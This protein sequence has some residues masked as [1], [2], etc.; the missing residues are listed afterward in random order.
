MI[1]EPLPANLQIQNALTL[2]AWVYPTAY[3]TINSG[4]YYAQIMGS[5]EDGVYGG[6]GLFISGANNNGD[7]VPTGGI[8]F[9][10]GDGSTFHG[11]YTASQVPLNQWTLVTAV[12][13]AGNPSQIYFNGVA[14]PTITAGGTWSRTISYPNSDWFAIGQEVNENR[15]FTG[16]INDAQVYNAALTAAQFRAFT[17]RA[18]EA[19]ASKRLRPW[20]TGTAG[21]ADRAR[22]LPRQ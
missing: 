18:A 11:T 9:N 16:L 15:P 13:T 21:E 14:Q 6:A 2:S 1:G 3:P 12:A 5:Q 19:S 22:Q 7:G 4:G 20:I 8:I 10:L 17:A